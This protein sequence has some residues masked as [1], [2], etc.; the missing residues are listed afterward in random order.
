MYIYSVLDLRQYFPGKVF[1]PPKRSD[2]D[3]RTVGKDFKRLLCLTRNTANAALY[4]DRADMGLQQPNCR[5]MD[6]L[7]AASA[8]FSL[9]NV[10]VEWAEGFFNLWLNWTR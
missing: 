6:D 8:V 5:D 10:G 4:A 3:T 2:V 9:A 1:V 7:A